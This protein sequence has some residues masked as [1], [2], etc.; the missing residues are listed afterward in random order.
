MS[1]APAKRQKKSGAPARQASRVASGAK[2]LQ[3]D[4]D[5]TAP[6]SAASAANLGGGAAA[7]GQIAAPAPGVPS[8]KAPFTTPGAGPR[9]T[10]PMIH[11][12]GVTMA[13]GSKVILDDINLQVP[14][15]KITVVIGGSGSGKST[16][17]KL[18]VGFIRPTRGRI[19]VDGQDVLTLTP[20]ERMEVQKSIGMSFQYSAL[21][22]SMTVFDNV[23]FPLREHTKLS[24]PEIRTRVLAML[25]RIGLPGVEDKM[26]SDLSGGMKKRVGVARAIMLQPKIMLFD[27]PESG[28]D[29]IT[30]TS[31]AEL[32]KEMRDSFHITCLVI[33]HNLASTRLIA[34]K[35][36]MLYKGRIIAEGTPAELDA[37]PDPVLQ[38]FLH[39]RSQ[40]PY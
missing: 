12:D 5:P 37:N 40:G 17:L 15:G 21:F 16:T 14:L 6:T 2:P 23:A 9:G 27:E 1:P 4:S 24:E 19:W 3:S 25:E 30:T 22:D 10:D 38:Q 34:D 31:I 8:Q 39:G 33:S 26:P 36:C 20:A 7:P 35:V 18:I 11:L 29:P 13:F 28:L 32:I